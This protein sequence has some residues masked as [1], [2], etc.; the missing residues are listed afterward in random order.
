MSENTILVYVDQFKGAALPASWEALGAASLIA[1][2]LGGEVA[3]HPERV[4]PVGRHRHDGRVH[5]PPRLRPA[6]GVAGE[7]PQ[8]HRPAVEGAGRI[9]PGGGRADGRRVENHAGPD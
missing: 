3:R 6:D 1:E 4:H 5:S 7:H 9:G 8:V 2:K